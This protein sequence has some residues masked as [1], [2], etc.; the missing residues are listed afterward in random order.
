MRKGERSEL[1]DVEGLRKLLTDMP[2]FE[3]RWERRLV[4]DVA[5]SELDAV[6]IEKVVSSAQRLFGYPFPPDAPKI[7]R[8]EVLNLTSHGQLH[9]GAV[10]LFGR[11]PHRRFP[12]TR[13]RAIRFTDQAQRDIQDNKVFEGHAFKL[14]DAAEQFIL[15]HVPVTGRIT[16]A[17]LERGDQPKLPRMA[18]REA[19]LNSVQHRDYESYDGSIIINITPTRLSI[20][21][22]GSLPEGLTIKELK[23]VHYSRPRNPDIAHAFF[24]R[25][26]VERVGSGTSRILTALRE[27]GLPDAE[28]QTVSGGLEIV[29]GRRPS[30]EINERQQDVL[31]HLASGESIT[32]SEY[33]LRF[34]G[35][36]SAR[37]ARADLS[38]LVKKGLLAKRGSARSTRYERTENVRT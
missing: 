14:V 9:N 29:F 27:A 26:L 35:G 8:L 7:S 10:V 31:A 28:W 15:S 12:Q 4:G 2:R 36:V 22:P 1:A 11:E 5:E 37:Q 19:L 21:N 17:R 33:T 6:E 34:A 24:L 30:T 23:G 3:V 20:W 38:E 18:I 13:V 32:L 25:G 16:D